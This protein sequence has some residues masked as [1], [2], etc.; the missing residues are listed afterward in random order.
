MIATFAQYNCFAC[1]AISAPYE[2]R[3]VELP[4]GEKINTLYISASNGTDKG[5]K[6]NEATPPV[7]MLHGTKCAALKI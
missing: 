1:E 5:E 6:T 7:V 3:M 4:S 2:Q